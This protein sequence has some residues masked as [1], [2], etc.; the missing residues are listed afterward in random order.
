MTR[1]RGEHSTTT[2][3][4]DLIQLDFFNFVQ[5]LRINIRF[6]DEFYS[7]H[8]NATHNENYSPPL[9]TH[10]APFTL[11]RVTHRPTTAR[12]TRNNLHLVQ[13]KRRTLRRRCGCD[14][15]IMVSLTV[16]WI[17]LYLW[18]VVPQRRLFVVSLVWAFGWKNKSETN[19]TTHK[20]NSPGI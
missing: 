20:S 10:S 12:R 18:I 3:T 4:K 16:P 11:C 7:N 2:S 13:H 8:F 5:K 6:L 9:F 17:R 19:S 1:E 15:L 14:R